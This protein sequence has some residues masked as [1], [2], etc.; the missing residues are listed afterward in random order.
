MKI[1]IVYDSKFGNNKQIAEVLG[2]QFSEDQNDVHV[3][4]AKKVKPQEA[5]DADMLFFGGPIHL[6]AITFTAKGWVENFAKI[7]SSNKKTLKKVAVWGTHIPDKPNTPPNVTWE[8]NALKWKVLMDSIA[9][10][11]RM[12]ATQGFLIK[13]VDGRDTLEDTWLSIVTDFAGRIKSL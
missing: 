11:K 10:E 1:W 13:A 5:I 12:P 2:K 4:Y 9:A 7:L 8:A 6:G 3:Q